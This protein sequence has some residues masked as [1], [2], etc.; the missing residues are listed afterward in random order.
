MALDPWHQGKDHVL[1]QQLFKA[2]VAGLLQLVD[3]VRRNLVNPGDI[4]ASG[5]EDAQ[6][7]GVDVVHRHRFEGHAFL[8]HCDLFCIVDPR[9]LVAP[10]VENTIDTAL[11]FDGRRLARTLD[12]AADRSTIGK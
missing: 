4:Q 9:E 8:Q 5:L 7:L 3:H 2:V 10:L 11:L 1:D 12:N 6:Q